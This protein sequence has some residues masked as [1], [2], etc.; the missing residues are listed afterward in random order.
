MSSKSQELWQMATPQTFKAGIFARHSSS[1]VRE[2][3][4]L[5]SGMRLSQPRFRMPP[6]L[7]YCRVADPIDEMAQ[8]AETTKNVKTVLFAYL[9]ISRKHLKE[10]FAG[11]DEIIPKKYLYVVRPLVA[12]AYLREFGTLPPLSLQDLLATTTSLPGPI[13]AALLRLVD[14]KMTDLL[15]S[16]GPRSPELDDWVAAYI[17]ECETYGRTLPFLPEPPFPQFNAI[18]YRAV[19]SQLS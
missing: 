13:K 15:P 17:T 5:V 12:V 18:F 9:S 14:D 11:K 16:R 19:V 10:H 7:V 6:F 8:I 3:L 4:S 1:Y 2:I